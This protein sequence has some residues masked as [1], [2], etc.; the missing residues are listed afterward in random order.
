[1]FKNH[2]TVVLLLCRSVQNNTLLQKINRV[3]AGNSGRNR[4]ENLGTELC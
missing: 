4:K 1:M 3:Y 2:N